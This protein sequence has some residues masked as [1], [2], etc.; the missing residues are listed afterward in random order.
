[1][2]IT[3]RSISHSV[4]FV[5]RFYEEYER[6][7]GDKEEAVVLSMAELLIPGFLGIVADAIGIIVIGVSSI[8]LMKKVAIFGAFWSISIIFTE[9]LLNRLMIAY[10]PAPKDT[11]HYVPTPIMA[12][13]KRIAF[14]ST[15]PASQRVIVGVWLVIVVLCMTVAL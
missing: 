3:A 9:M 7:N 12:V 15:N 11:S 10:F 6:L 2:V 4:Q 1:M 13:L 8:A 14:L 5:E